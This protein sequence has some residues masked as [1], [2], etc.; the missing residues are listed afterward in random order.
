MRIGFIG[1][2]LMGQPMA[3]NMAKS[4]VPLIL[5]NRSV[6]KYEPFH[7]TD[8]QIA[9][10]AE[11][12][13]KQASVIFLM[14]ANNTVIDSILNRGTPKF[15][16]NVADRTIVHM[17]TTSPEYSR[18]L[19]AD[20]RAAGGSY[21][22]APVSG[23][24]KPAESGELVSMVAG[25]A[26][27]IDTIY[28]LLQS[29]CRD[30]FIC[31][32]VPN[33]LF[34]KLSVNLFLI[35]MVTGLAESFH[36]AEQQGLD[37]KQLQAILDAGPMASN[38]SKVKSAKLATEDFSAQASIS[39]VLMNN[40]L[41]YEAARHSKIASP[42]LDTCIRLYT[43]T[44]QLGYAQTDMVNVIKAIQEKTLIVRR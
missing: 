26:A 23:S 41:I 8:A 33:A 25:E 19:E 12:V 21:I 17:G 14:L 15:T 39:D 18:Q 6:E 11:D 10:T 36:F 40:Q 42:L 3:L 2:G 44:E 24:R 31:G 38:V 16:H 7:L 1:L 9:S 29:M 30:I 13:F 22:E 28:P 43:E 27:D 35:S 20:I 4:G 37:I 32:A 5:W 34:M